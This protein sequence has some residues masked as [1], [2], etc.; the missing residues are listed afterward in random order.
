M[1]QLITIDGCMTC[2]FLVTNCKNTCIHPNFNDE[3]DGD[4][5]VFTDEE[6]ESEE[7]PH[8]CPLIH[9]SLTV[10]LDTNAER[11]SA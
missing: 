7:I 8:W 1:E 11:N 2:P 9:N 4:G 6:D 5:R 10:K 3:Q